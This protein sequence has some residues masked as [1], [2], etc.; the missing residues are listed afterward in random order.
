M[1]ISGDMALVLIWVHIIADFFM[2]TRKMATNKSKS[3]KW[4]FT[5]VCVYTIPFLYF[6]VKFALLNL[7]LHFITD[8]ISSR[9]TSHFWSKQN[10]YA[11]F[12]TIGIDQGIHITCLIKTYE[13]LCL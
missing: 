11:F 3:N 2:Q 5:H 9:I 8:F 10:G 4:L 7:V 6:G 1:H 12:G 13:W